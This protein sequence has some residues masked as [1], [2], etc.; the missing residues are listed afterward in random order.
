RPQLNLYRNMEKYE[1]LK[2]AIKIQIPLSPAP[3]PASAPAHPRGGGSRA[4]PP[5]G[6]KQR[7]AGSAPLRGAM[8]RLCPPG[9]SA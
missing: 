1:N 4:E 7:S 6:R 9:P 8:Q 2:N 3:A 5:A